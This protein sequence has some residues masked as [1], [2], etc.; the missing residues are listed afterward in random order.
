MTERIPGLRD[1]VRSGGNDPARFKLEDNTSTNISFFEEAGRFPWKQGEPN[2]DE[3]K[4]NC[5]E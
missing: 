4:E 1:K 2:D 5:V 3:G